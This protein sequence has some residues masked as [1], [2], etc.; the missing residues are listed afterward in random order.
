M[1]ESIKITE[2]IT[3]FA[4]HIPKNGKILGIDYGMR[5]VGIAITDVDRIIPTP[6]KIMQNNEKFLRNLSDLIM[7]NQISAIAIGIPLDENGNADSRGENIKKFANNIY[8]IVKL[9]I[10]LMDERMTSKGAQKSGIY[11]GDFGKQSLLHSNRRIGRKITQNLSWMNKNNQQLQSNKKIKISLDLID[12]NDDA[13]AASM[14]LEKV[15]QM[16]NNL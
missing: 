11:F 3:D 7:E 12:F 5:K 9:P 14:L 8:N 6:L 4:N 2:N 10:L 15:L 1:Q 16:L 13:V